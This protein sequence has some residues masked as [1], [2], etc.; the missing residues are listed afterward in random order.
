MNDDN[1]ESHA[2]SKKGNNNRSHVFMTWRVHQFFEQ[3]LESVETFKLIEVLYRT[4]A[5]TRVSRAIVSKLESDNRVANSFHEVVG[6]VTVQQKFHV[7]DRFRTIFRQNIR[8][9]F[10]EKQVTTMGLFMKN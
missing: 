8:N 5:E 7:P 9:I 1:H 4:V 6:H 3:E 10:M 2:I